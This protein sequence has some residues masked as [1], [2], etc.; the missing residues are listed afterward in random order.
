MEPFIAFS[1]I[2][3]C[4]LWKIAQKKNYDSQK[5]IVW[6]FFIKASLI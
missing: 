3:G 6:H 1:S 4:C 5:I 2:L